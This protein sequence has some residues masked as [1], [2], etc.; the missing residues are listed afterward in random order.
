MENEHTDFIIRLINFWLTDKP[1]FFFL[2]LEEFRKV[3]CSNYELCPHS[4]VISLFHGQT[5]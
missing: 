5:D 2:R 3:S 4:V 1:Q